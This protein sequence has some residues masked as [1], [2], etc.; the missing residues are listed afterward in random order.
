[1]KL[2]TFLHHLHFDI[3][4]I[5][6]PDWEVDWEDAPLPYKLYRNLPVIPL[7]SE[8]PLTFEGREA[9]EKLDLEGIGHFL[10]YVFGLTQFCQLAF[11]MGPTEQAENL[12]HLYRRFVPSGGAL[13]PNELY[14]YLKMEDVSE[15]VYHYDVAHHRLVLLREGN[16]D[17]YLTRA[18]GNRCD[19][20]ACFGMVFVSTM[21]WKNFF[22]Y[23]NFAYRLQGLDA[24]VLIGQLL[25]AAKQFGFASTVYFQFLDRAINHLLGLSEQE[26]SV[27]AVIAL[28]VESFITW[29]ANDNNLEE[30]VSATELC[31]ELPAVQ[32]HY[33]IRSRRII[34][35]PM[36]RKMN[37]AS[38]LESSRSF[39]QIK[40]KKKDTCEVQAVVLPCVKRLSY[41]LASVCQKRYS[42]GMDFVLGKV[43]QEQLA[44][45]LQEAT[46]FFTY[47]NDLDG[48]YEKPPS[49]VSLY[50]CFYNVEDVPNGAYYYD[51]A[52]HALRRIRSG[53]YRHYLQYGM[54]MDNVN[55]FQVPLCLHVVGDRDHLQMELGYRGYRIQQMEAGMLVQRLLLVASAMGMGGHPLLGFDVNLCDKL[56]K[57][58]SR[59]KTSLIQIPI[60]HYCPRAWL[61]GSLRS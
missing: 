30:N 27:Y 35:Y 42:P 31:R 57:I 8:V 55:L 48:E 12:M 58:D 1:M 23:N 33:Y 54:S 5:M 59:W 6:P 26:E 61:K 32:H 3:D 9:P 39:R 60:G 14:V 46:L 56:Y 19:V 21:F 37:E 11:S 45:L 51:S 36:L 2:D 24:G 41:D 40:R 50:G 43:S 53:D 10:W 15:G 49:R 17:S 13:Y 25:E 44:T 22:K 16:F 47:R 4:K 18:L 29:F 52:V 20:S 28:S 7:S 38:M 34:D